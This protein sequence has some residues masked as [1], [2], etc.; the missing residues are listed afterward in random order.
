VRE[1]REETGLMCPPDSL[2][3]LA[4]NVRVTIDQS[5]VIDK[6][7]FLT[8]LPGAAIALDG[9]EHDS[10]CWVDSTE[11]DELLYWDSNRRT[12]DIVKDALV[13]G[14]AGGPGSDQLRHL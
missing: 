13:G 2:R 8:W 3:E 5:L 11:V 10:Y 4:A 1:V 6:T 12:W 14:P 9:K 7:L